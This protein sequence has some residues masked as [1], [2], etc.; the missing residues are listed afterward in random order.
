MSTAPGGSLSMAEA[1]ALLEAA[2]R[3]CTAEESA[4]LKR[5]L[6]ELLQEYVS[7]SSADY[8]SPAIYAMLQNATKALE[9]RQQTTP[10]RSTFSFKSVR[11]RVPTPATDAAVSVPSK[12]PSD[13][14]PAAHATPK[15]GVSV[16]NGTLRI[17]GLSGIDVVRCDAELQ[18]IGTVM[19]KDLERCRVILLGIVEAVY[20]T[21]IK[22]SLIWIGAARGSAILHSLCDSTM[23]IC[24][25]QLRIANSVGSKFLTD[26]VTMPIIER[27]NGVSFAKNHVRY[28]GQAHH[29]EA[30]GLKD[31]LMT[32]AP[33]ATDF[34]W[35]HSGASPNWSSEAERPEVTLSPEP[36]DQPASDLA[37]NTF[38]FAP[39][40]WEMLDHL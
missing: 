12:E 32:E 6:E 2:R 20:I 8:F 23:L 29:L 15:K 24:C 10:V 36:I 38:T 25:R 11:T 39:E 17:Q 4:R 9:G 22:D 14:A 13:V 28:A 5:R 26:T 35:H 27:T 37:G 7:L 18:G 3:C 19:M 33:A 31:V 40:S 1:E 21:D 30:S 34:S 16:E